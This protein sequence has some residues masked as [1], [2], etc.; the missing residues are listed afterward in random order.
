MRGKSVELILLA[1]AVFAGH[2]LLAVF[3]LSRLHKEPFFA[4]FLLCLFWASG[5]FCTAFTLR[6]LGL[7]YYRLSRERI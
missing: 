1:T 4:F 6:R 5:L 7:A 3:A 2:L